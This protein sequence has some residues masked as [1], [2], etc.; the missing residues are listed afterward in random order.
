MEADNIDAVVPAAG[1]YVSQL[2]VQHFFDDSSM[3]FHSFTGWMVVMTNVV[4][5][6][7]AAVV[8]MFVV[9][10]VHSPPVD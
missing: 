6:I 4:N 1:P 7:A 8:L 3:D 5:A 9:S 10:A 2:S